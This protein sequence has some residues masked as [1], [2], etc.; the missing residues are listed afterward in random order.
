MLSILPSTHCPL[1]KSEK[2]QGGGK[3]GIL[4][5]NVSDCLYKLKGGCGAEALHPYWKGMDLPFEMIRDYT[6]RAYFAGHLYP[7]KPTGTRLDLTALARRGI[8]D[9]FLNEPERYL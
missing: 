8:T 9:V 5:R 1:R 4:D 6:V 7:E 3:T 2:Y